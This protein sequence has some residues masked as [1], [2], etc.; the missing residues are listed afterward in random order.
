MSP[1]LFFIN[2]FICTGVGIIF[3]QINSAAVAFIDILI[4]AWEGLTI[5]GSCAAK[6]YESLLNVKH[7]KTSWLNYL[8]LFSAC[9]A[10]WEPGVSH[11]QRSEEEDCKG[12]NSGACRERKGR[13]NS[14]ANWPLEKACKEN[15]IQKYYLHTCNCL[16]RYSFALQVHGRFNILNPMKPNRIQHH[17]NATFSILPHVKNPLEGR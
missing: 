9:Q 4:A 10:A 2:F 1:I 15:L 8:L 5:S 6:F 7:I 11:D 13:W 16:Y 3:W 14:L 12:V 17:T